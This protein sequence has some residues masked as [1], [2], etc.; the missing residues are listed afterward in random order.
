MHFTITLKCTKLLNNLFALL[1]LFLL[2]DFCQGL[3]FVSGCSKGT[4]KPSNRRNLLKKLSTQA[5]LLSQIV[6][7]ILTEA[8]ET[9]G[10]DADCNDTSCLGVWDGM[11]A[12]CPHGKMNMM[13]GAGCASSQDDT[14]GVFAE[15]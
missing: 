15:P 4:L 7:P 5:I 10:K 2:H 8:A 13:S 9:V 3:S 12:D 11:L 1:L 14:P 6:K